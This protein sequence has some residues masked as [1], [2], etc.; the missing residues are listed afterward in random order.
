MEFT[1]ND[2]KLKELLTDVIVEI[3]KNR[4]D[5]LYDIILEAFEEIGLANAIMDGSKNDFV[6]EEKIFAIIDSKIK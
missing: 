2:E 3:I 1:L 4:R 5:V 6:P